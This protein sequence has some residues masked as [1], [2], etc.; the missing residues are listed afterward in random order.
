V[1]WSAVF[2]ACGVLL[3]TTVSPRPAAADPITVSFTALP[4]AG[5]PVNTVPTSGYFVFDSSLIPPGGGTVQDSTFGLGALD[6]GFRWSSTVWTPA[7]A[8]LG[9]LLFSPSGTLLGWVIGGTASPTGMGGI[10]SYIE[11]P[12][13]EVIDDIFASSF[14]GVGGG[15]GITYTNAG[16]AGA[17]DGRLVWHF[18]PSPIPE[19]SSLV[20]LG[21][22]AA[23][24]VTRRSRRRATVTDA[25]KA[26]F[27]R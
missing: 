7:N 23:L 22:G 9:E 12:A 19:P 24:L 1:A 25:Q 13:S 16:V 8:D 3:L 15:S 20:L 11:A 17:L 26:A 10:Y 4:A 27:P 2:L 5:D 18:A 14:A 21:T 6:I